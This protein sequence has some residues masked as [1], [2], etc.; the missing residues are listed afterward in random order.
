[1]VQLLVCGTSTDGEILSSVSQHNSDYNNKTLKA[2]N[3]RPTTISGHVGSCC[4][5]Y[6]LLYVGLKLITACFQFYL[7]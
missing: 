2:K 4:N 6:S 7:R 1:M 3:E 5:L